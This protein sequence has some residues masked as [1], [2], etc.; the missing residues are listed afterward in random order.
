MYLANCGSTMI[1]PNSASI[2][3]AR[4]AIDSVKL[5]DV[6]VRRSSRAESVRCSTI[7]RQMKTASRI[8]P[9]VMGTQGAT[10]AVPMAAVPM[11]LSP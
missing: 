1:V 10:G 3:V 8:S 2:A 4:S 5:R 11:L 7:C 6:N 9:I